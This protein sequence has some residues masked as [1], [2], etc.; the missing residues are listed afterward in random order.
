MQEKMLHGSMQRNI[1]TADELVINIVW[2]SLL[3]Y[4]LVYV[5]VTAK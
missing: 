4:T 2:D 1:S 3:Q 5:V